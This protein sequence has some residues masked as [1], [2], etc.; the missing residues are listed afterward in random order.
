M[1]SF[2]KCLNY[3]RYV[4]PFLLLKTTKQK[5]VKTKSARALTNRKQ[6]N[7]DYGNKIKNKTTQVHIIFFTMD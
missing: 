3:M 5:L 1:D 4:L 6:L 2:K 7:K